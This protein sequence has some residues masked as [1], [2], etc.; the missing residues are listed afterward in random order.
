MLSGRDDHIVNKTSE[1]IYLEPYNHI[2]VQNYSFL[3]SLEIELTKGDV[4]TTT[5]LKKRGILKEI[6]ITD[7]PMPMKKTR[8]DFDVISTYLN[9]QVTTENR[10]GG[11]DSTYI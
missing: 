4:N 1:N 7:G 10:I 5:E 9:I 11:M 6:T 3:P 8:V 2:N